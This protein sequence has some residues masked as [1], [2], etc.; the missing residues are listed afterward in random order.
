[1]TTHIALPPGGPISCSRPQQAPSPSPSQDPT[2]SPTL[3]CSPEP[4]NPENELLGLEEIK[5]HAITTIPRDSPPRRNPFPNVKHYR[6]EDINLEYGWIILMCC[7][8]S[9]G[10]I[11][12]VS[13]SSWSVFVGI[14]TG[15]FSFCIP[16]KSSPANRANLPGNT[17]FA[18]LGLSHQPNSIS[19]HIRTKALISIGSF[20]MGSVL[21]GHL[22]RHAGMLRRSIMSLSSL[23]QLLCVA[24]AAA[25]ATEGMVVPSRVA[26]K[27]DPASATQIGQSITNCTDQTPL[28]WLAVAPV[29]FLAFQAAGQVYLSRALGC[30][31]L[32]TIVLTSLY[33]DL[34]ANLSGIWTSWRKRETARDF[35][36]V[37]EKKHGRRF[38]AI[39]LL[40][41]GAVIGGFAS[42]SPGGPGGAL[43]VAAAVKLGI[44]VAW[45]FW[46]EDKASMV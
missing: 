24:T 43:W 33:C 19:P 45:F 10:I 14:Q 9:S 4:S 20:C 44:L 39:L 6:M 3:T 35:F 8:F 41:C 46:R 29:S 34:M 27:C 22:H 26:V 18:G 17:I 38:I 1:M 30:P 15:V 11:D 21:F 16:T 31:D 12:A 36:F 2:P 40:W 7:Y 32:P 28:T 25:L 23:I 13:Y 37:T 42:K 5:L